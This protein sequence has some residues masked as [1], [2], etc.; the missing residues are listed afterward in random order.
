MGKGTISRKVVPIS[1]FDQTSVKSLKFE[2]FNPKKK[3]SPF[4]SILPIYFAALDGRWGTHRF[5]RVAIEALDSIACATG[6][7]LPTD[8]IQVIFAA[9]KAQLVHVR[10]DLH[11]ARMKPSRE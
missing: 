9:E 7:V 4:N 5:P 3:T 2:A 1:K 6:V 10:W 11:N 8:R